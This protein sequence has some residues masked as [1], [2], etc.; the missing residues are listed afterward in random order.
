MDTGPEFQNALRVWEL[1]A[2]LVHHGRE[3]VL[4]L[5]GEHPP[6]QKFKNG[7]GPLFLSPGGVALGQV[8]QLCQPFIFFAQQFL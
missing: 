5:I 2:Q 1:R 4:P 8:E 7:H 3:I 6:L